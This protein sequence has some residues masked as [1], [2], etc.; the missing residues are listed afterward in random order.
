V[1]AS[2]PLLALLLLAEAVIRLTGAANKCP[3]PYQDSP[4]WAC[5]PILYFKLKP[6]LVIN[7]KPLNEAGFRTHEFTRKPASVY[8][9]LSLGDSCT[10]GMLVTDFF[11]YLP[12][13]YPQKLEELLTERAGPGKFEVLNAGTPG[14]NSFQ[15]VML[16]R[17][18]LRKLHPNLITVRYGWNDHL[19]SR[20]GRD[21]FRETDSKFGRAVEDV[22]LRTALYPFVLRLGLEWQSWRSPT[23]AKP[24]PADIPTEW[25]PNVPVDEYKE[26]LRRI[27]MLGR[28]QG[29]EVWL[30]TA[31]HALVTDENQ[32]RY[33]AFPNTMA[34]KALMTFSAIPTFERFVAIHNAYND[35]VREVG[36]ALD[37]PVVDMDAVYR[38]HSS[39]HLFSSTDIPHPTQ[40]G[41]D[42]E[43]ETLYAK[44]MEEG[45][46]RVPSG[47]IGSH[48]TGLLRTAHRHVSEDLRCDL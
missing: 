16:L 36:A 11:S 18:K 17:T 33:D 3:N 39:E 9:I 32:G 31:P 12:D 44:L 14:Y 46:V 1:F 27:V 34:A 38:A 19:M 28:A 4:L 5:D 35:A 30:L 15:G 42:L 47:G 20:S 29:A 7:G 13:P 41:H 48:P 37:A 26:N 24:T 2:V 43:A 10:F 25:K 22:L 23:N 40:A 45:I 6:S 8:R 21:N